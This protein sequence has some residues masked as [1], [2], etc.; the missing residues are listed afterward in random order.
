MKHKPDAY[1]LEYSGRGANVIKCDKCGFRAVK[2]QFDEEGGCPKCQLKFDK[3]KGK[4]QIKNTKIEKGHFK[5][6]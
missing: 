5:E 2:C 6:E 3:T 4:N 1:E